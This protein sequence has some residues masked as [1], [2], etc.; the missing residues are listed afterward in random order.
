MGV[1]VDKLALGQDF[2][3]LLWFTPVSII[4]P[5]LHILSFMYQ[6]HYYYLRHYVIKLKYFF[7]RKK[8]RIREVC[9]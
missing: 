3:Q 9:N 5:M 2:L 1:A 7:F 8:L 4:S 6:W